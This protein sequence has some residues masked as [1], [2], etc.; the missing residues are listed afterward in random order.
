MQVFDSLTG[1]PAWIADLDEPA[2]CVA[3][4]PDGRRV[5]SGGWSGA[6]TLHDAQSG[7]LVARFDD[8]GGSINAVAVDP[9]GQLVA[10][11]AGS[12]CSPGGRLHKGEVGLR[13]W[14]AHSGAVV[15]DVRGPRHAV[16][17]VAISGDQLLAIVEDGTLRAWRL[18]DGRPCGRVDLTL[19]DDRPTALAAAGHRVLVGTQAGW[20][21]AFALEEGECR[22]S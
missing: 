12:G 8:V 9:S 2:L 1:I 15:R 10:T 17:Q 7:A 14:D 3:W 16:A 20:V 11:G 5:L 6:L 21:A 13:L 18:R 4:S 19:V 22:S